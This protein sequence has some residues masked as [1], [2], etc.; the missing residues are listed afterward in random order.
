[1]SLIYSKELPLEN[2]IEN[3]ELED[4]FGRKYNVDEVIGKVGIIIAVMCN[5]CPYSNAIWQRLE[6]VS[7]FAKK[8]DITT[9]AIN[10]NIHP[11]FCLLYTSPSPRD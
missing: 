4:A 1:M 3:F 8:L 9:L 11:N 5:H 6:R 2:K 7:E 10:P